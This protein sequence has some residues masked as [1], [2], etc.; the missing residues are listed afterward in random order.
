MTVILPHSEADFN[1][2]LVDAVSAEV[3]GSIESV[4]DAFT[5]A[6]L[7]DQHLDMPSEFSVDSY[8]MIS[9]TW[10]AR[11]ACRVLQVNGTS[12]RETIYDA[13]RPYAFHY[14]VDEFRGGLEG[15]ADLIVAYYMFVPLGLRTLVHWEH[16]IRP[17]GYDVIPELE[18]FMRNAWRPWKL[19]AIEQIGAM[20]SG[21]HR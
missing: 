12:M 20:L 8:E 3:P 2:M 18:S 11:G 10:P 16:A 6:E 5:D 9:G 21:R 1:L 14:F 15:K 7:I 17:N 19:R 13:R 4:F